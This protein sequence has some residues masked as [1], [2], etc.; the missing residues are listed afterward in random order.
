MDPIDFTSIIRA[1]EGYAFLGLCDEAWE[2]VK[3]L[4]PQN[5]HCPRAFAVRLLICTHLKKWETGM[6]LALEFDTHSR[7]EARE[8][9]GRF[10]LAYATL[11][12]G[13]NRLTA[14]ST[15]I[16]LMELVWPEGHREALRS[17]ALQR[18][19]R[20]DIPDAEKIPPGRS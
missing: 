7:I 1:A 19:W 9:A 6:E 13:N 18:L 8:A 5:Q 17:R 11:L 12:A 15:V 20:Q 3:S 14:A 2:L 16:S 10:Y 4:P